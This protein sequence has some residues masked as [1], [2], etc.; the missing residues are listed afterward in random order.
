MTPEHDQYLC[1]H[2]P[3]LYGQRGGHPN[4]TSMC[5]GFECGDGWF[6]LIRKLS[7]QIENYNNALPPDQP[8]IEATQVKEKFGTLRFYTNSYPPVLDPWIQ[9]AEETSA[10]TCEGCG[11][12]GKLVRQGGWLSTF[13]S[14]CD[15]RRRADRK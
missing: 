6:E 5:W 4:S 7:E 11:Q 2:Y 8:P 9:E 12:E 15:V 13:C 1:Q 14:D 10:K 3:K